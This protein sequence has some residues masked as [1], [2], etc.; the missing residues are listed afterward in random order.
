LAPDSQ[1][2]IELK[3]GTSIEELGERLTEETEENGNPIGR[4]MVPNDPWELL[5]TKPPT[6][7][8]TLADLKPKHIYYLLKST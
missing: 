4:P 3:S 7:E 6:K 1:A 5:G 2:S 8:H